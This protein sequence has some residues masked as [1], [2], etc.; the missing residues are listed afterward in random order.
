MPFAY[1]PGASLRKEG[2]VRASLPEETSKIHQN[3]KTA[4]LHTFHAEAFAFADDFFYGLRRRRKRGAFACLKFVEVFGGAGIVTKQL[5]AL[6]VACSPPRPLR[7][8]A[9]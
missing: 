8:Q 9:V 1:A 5:L 4:A 6:G 2:Y 3:T 7:E